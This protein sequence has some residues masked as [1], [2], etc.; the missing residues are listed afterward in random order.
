MVDYVCINGEWNY[1]PMVDWT[2]TIP[3]PDGST[4]PITQ[5]NVHSSQKM[6][7]VWSNPAGKDNHHLQHLTAKYQQ[8]IDRS[9][10]GHLSNRNKSY[11]FKLYPGLRYGLA[12]LAMPT[13]QITPIFR[14]QDYC[15]LP[16]L[17]INRSIKREWRNIPQAFGGISLFD[18]AVEQ[19]IGWVNMTLQHYK[20]PTTLGQKLT[21]TLE[22]LQLELGC[23]RNPLQECY[24]TTGILA[25]PCW[26]TSVWEHCWQYKLQLI[27]EYDNLLLPCKNATTL[28]SLFVQQGIRGMELRCRSRCRLALHAYHCKWQI[29]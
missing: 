17:G 15:A 6:L 11:R 14:H 24:T 25:T 4:H 8:W 16:L 3:M 27:L 13:M 1:A 10:N 21:T 9:T 2:I 29:S 5:L 23:T 19:L 22:A 7:G 20:A 12:T 26:I 28:V 18:L